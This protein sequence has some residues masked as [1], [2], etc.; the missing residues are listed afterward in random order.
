MTSNQQR[1]HSPFLSYKFRRCCLLTALLAGLLW[2]LASG[3]HA[4]ELTHFARSQLLET[5]TSEEDYTL[6]LGPMKNVNGRWQPDSELLVSGNWRRQ[7]FELPKNRPLKDVLTKYL[8]QLR[9]LGASPLFVCSGHNCG[10]SGSWANLHFNERRL[11][12]LDQYQHYLA[13]QIN[14]GDQSQIV[15]VYMATR[16]NQRSYL[17]IDQIHAEQAINHKV[18]SQTVSTLLE[19]GQRIPLPIEFVGRQWQLDTDLLALIARVMKLSPTMKLVV[20]ASDQRN[21]SLDTNL[22]NS[23]AI[24]QAAVDQ[25]IA[26]KV[27]ADRLRAEGIGNLAATDDQAVRVWV[28]QY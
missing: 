17:L 25:L 28:F 26:N 13:Y 9:A 21:K 6:A 10:S 27:D 12:G 3:V 15:V 16:G 8:Q 4:L 22:E 19:D 5:L 18:S 1:T 23:E 7:L 14:E 11:Y 20:V 24:A 2:P